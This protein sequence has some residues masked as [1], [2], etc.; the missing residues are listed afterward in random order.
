MV[1]RFTIWPILIFL[2]RNFVSIYLWYN[3]GIVADDIVR[4]E[5]VFVS[6]NSFSVKNDITIFKK[7]GMGEN[8]DE[9]SLT[10]AESFTKL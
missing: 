2:G 6:H 10:I 4:V 1:N 9:S 5:C 3:Y 7:C 8:T